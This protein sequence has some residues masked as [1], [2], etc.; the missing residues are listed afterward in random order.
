[1]YDFLDRLLTEYEK[2]TQEQIGRLEPGLS[3]DEVTAA[4]MKIAETG[5]QYHRVIDTYLKNYLY[6]VLED[7]DNITNEGEEEL[8]AAAQRLSSYAVRLDPGLALKIYQGLLEWSRRTKNDSKIIRYLY[9]CGITMFYFFRG[10]N[11]SS[12]QDEK[13]LEY[14]TQGAAYADRYQMFGDP[15]TRRYIHR[16]IG[17]AIMMYYTTGNGS[18]A[19]EAEEAGFSFWNGLL[20]TGKDL[21]FPWLNY[22]LSCLNHKHGYM[23]RTAH[24]NPD[25]VTRAELK[26]ILDISITVNKLYKKNRELFS[27][28][29]GARYEFILWEAQFLCGQ[30]SFDHLYENV[31]KKKAEFAEDDFSSDALFVRIQ[32]NSYLMFYAAKMAKL[33]DRKDEIIAK[34][35]K[36]AIEF[37]SHIPMTV[38]PS[39]LSEQLQFFAKNLSDVFSPSEQMDFILKMTTY[40]H[41]PTYAHSITVGKLSLYLAKRMIEDDPG[42]FIGCMG[43]ESAEEARRRA[44]EIYQ[45]IDTACLCHDIGKISYIS[46]PFMHTRVLTDE[47]YAIIKRH[48]SDGA[49]MLEREGDDAASN[50]YI[51]ITRGHHRDYDNGGGYPENC[52][53]SLS[54]FKILIDIVA[55]ANVIDSATDGISRTYTEPKDTE[56]ICDEII[57]GA[58]RRYTP[59]AAEVLKSKQAR[60]DIAHILDT[61][62]KAAY[63]TAYLHAWAD[64]R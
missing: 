9:W 32:L 5:R 54:R 1:M 53:T 15:E 13:I 48:P 4:C 42:C 20:F 7:I 51:E 31:Y 55:V 46:N 40:R 52:D 47:E 45:I 26:D 44:D 37:F 38:S 30:I 27:V 56:T 36:D 35:S 63:Y 14:F 16:C 24:T 25:S 18:K 41:I 11:Q 61:D 59:Y 3:Q 50:P 2:I 6:P 21:D 8:Y 28:W 17:N 23:M 62:R 49:E 19:A 34:V 64:D 33:S 39:V 57:E 58:G 29:G 22:F 12:D 43:I 60:A 10:Q